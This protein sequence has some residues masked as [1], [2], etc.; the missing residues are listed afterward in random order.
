M[1]AC[2][3][4]HNLRAKADVGT[5]PHLQR[6]GALCGNGLRLEFVTCCHKQLLLSC[7][8]GLNLIST[9][10]CVSDRTFEYVSCNCYVIFYLILE[11]S[12]RFFFLIATDNKEKDIRSDNGYWN[13]TLSSNYEKKC[14]LIEAPFFKYLNIRINSSLVK[15]FLGRKGGSARHQQEKKSKNSKI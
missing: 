1:I 2:L 13:L 6:F 4:A 9:A 7:Y 5:L 12:Y 8:R 10:P 15:T 3:H 14:N 11:A